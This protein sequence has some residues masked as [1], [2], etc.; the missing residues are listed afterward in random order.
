MKTSDKKISLGVREE[1]GQPLDPQARLLHAPGALLELPALVPRHSPLGDGQR[2]DE[3]ED[4]DLGAHQLGGEA[5]GRGRS[6]GRRRVT[7]SG[8]SSSSSP[9]ASTS[10]NRMR[11]ARGSPRCSSHAPSWRSV[12]SKRFDSPTSNREWETMAASCASSSW[13]NRAAACSPP[14]G[15]GG[16]ACLAPGEEPGGTGQPPSGAT[17]CGNAS[18]RAC[19]SRRRSP[20]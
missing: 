20:R 8:A 17:R 15:A 13:G 10:R 3:P 14:A 9:G 18:P 4:E 1:L 7:D 11:S 5:H 19:S 2:G 16:G 12:L 6:G